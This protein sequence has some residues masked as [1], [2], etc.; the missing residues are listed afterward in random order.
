MSLP[1]AQQ[2]SAITIQLDYSYDANHFFDSAAKKSVLSAAAHY[3][4]TRLNDQ[5]GA[6]QSLGSNQFTAQFSNPATGAT[7]SI[8]NFNVAANTLKVFA[9]GRD[10][11]GSTVGQGGPGGY[12][13]SGQSS[14][15]KE[16]ISR[17]QGDG[18]VSAVSGAGAKDFAPWGGSIT[19]ATNTN[20]YFDDNVSTVESFS[21]ND[22]YSV[23]LHELGHL[24]GFGTADSWDNLV[25][26]TDF[27]G[28]E[29]SS[30]YGD[31]NSNPV[32]LSADKSHWLNGTQSL[33]DAVTQQEAAMDP[34]LTT[35]TRKYFTDLDLAALKDIGWEVSAV[36]V[37]AAIYLFATALMG[38]GLMRRKTV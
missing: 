24:L 30:V 5:L 36:P 1:M 21:G 33:V 13:I 35:G 16:A 14:F 7:N 26:G 15:F 34:S 32:P 9:G 28:P 19:F 10:L 12:D 29:S 37:P 8:S 38:F 6:I 22:F 18:T 2:A 23:A 4:E 11:S 27:V 25:S 31:P 3:F 17:G 20:W